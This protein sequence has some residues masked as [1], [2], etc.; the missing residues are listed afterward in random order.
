[1]RVTDRTAKGLVG[2]GFRLRTSM[3]RGRPPGAVLVAVLAS[4]LLLSVAAPASGAH[5][6]TF[7]D[8]GQIEPDTVQMH[9][10]LQPDGD[11]EW[12]IR[13][14]VRLADENDTAAFESLARDV[15]E[16]RS[17]F[18][19][20][21]ATRIDGTVTAAQNATGR[22]MAVA[23]VSVRT[24]RQ[25]IPQRYGLLVYSFEWTNFA[26]ADGA[27]IRAGDA[28]A[29]LF[30]DDVTS[31][32]VEWPPGYGAVTV[33]PEADDTGEA[34]VTW[35]G[36][37]EFTTEQPEI[38]VSTESPGSGTEP[39]SNGGSETGT[40][41]VGPI[42]IATVGLL[43]LVA[44]FAGAW[45]WRRHEPTTSEATDS[46]GPS[47]PPDEL[48]SNEE[49]VLQLLEAHGGRMKQQQVVEELGWTDAKTS[50]VVGDLRESGEVEGFR[51]GRENVLR[52]PEPDEDD[53]S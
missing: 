11:A 19:D 20:R 17:A 29:G 26:R 40:G 52:L 23:N 38:V 14:R 51:L 24:E 34:S 41:G 4:A 33:D 1:M 7:A 31:L 36:P 37:A 50:Q 42:A 46:T 35:R 43:G 16:N 30:L 12:E 28:I 53:E 2:G 3:V 21:F 39:P 47:A 27:T 48:L 6:S 15:R 32:T 10:A 45:W 25:E 9:V 13:Y 18:E 44:L 49:R 8:A 22:E 5:T